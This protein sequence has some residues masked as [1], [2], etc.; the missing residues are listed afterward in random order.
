MGLLFV[1]PIDETET[2][3]VKIEN[4]EHPKIHLASYGLPLIFWGYLLAILIVIFGMFL[5]A[6]DLLVKMRSGDDELNRWLALCAYS[7]LTL[8]PVGLLSLFFYEKII[9]KKGQELTITHRLFFLPFWK[10][11]IRFSKELKFH[12]ENFL[13]S[14]NVAKIQGKEEMRGFQNKGHFNLWA[15]DELKSI[16]IDRSSRKSDLL[17]MAKTLEK[18]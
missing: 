6:K 12:V 5:G 17:A 9:S 14:P 2:D 10:K 8:G 16:L 3:R 13:D 1:M 11:R 4:G 15:S 18:Y 7:L